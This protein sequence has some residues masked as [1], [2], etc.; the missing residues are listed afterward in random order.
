MTE[1]KNIPVIALTAD[2]MD[3]DIK[4]AMNMGFADYITKPIDLPKFLNSI[5]KTLA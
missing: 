2:A 4:K 3:G 1:T 5:N